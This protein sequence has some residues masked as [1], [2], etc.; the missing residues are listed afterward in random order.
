MTWSL[1]LVISTLKGVFVDLLIF[2]SQ[3]KSRSPNVHKSLSSPIDS[4]RSFFHLCIGY[5]LCS[6]YDTTVPKRGKCIVKTDLSIA[7]PLD[8][9]A[10]IAPRSGLAVKNFIDTGAGVVDYDYRGPVG[11]WL[12]CQLL[13]IHDCDEEGVGVGVGVGVGIELN[14][15][16]T[17]GHRTGSAV[18]GI[19]QLT[20]LSIQIHCRIL[21]S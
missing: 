9:Y 7:I 5:D 17:I 13:F 16:R 20:L 10:R 14:S 3:I 1:P 2:V 21:S 15:G 18:W 6:A 8:T 11:E 4:W 19:N 12:S